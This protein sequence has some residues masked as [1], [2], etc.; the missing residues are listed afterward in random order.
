[1][2]VI[3]TGA[4][5]YIGGEI[6]LKLRDAGHVVVGIDRRPCPA[7]LKSCF[8]DFI[9]QDFANEEVLKFI[10]RA[11][12][13]AIIHCAGT[14]LVGPSI[15]N[16]QE[17]YNNNVVK[18][19]KLLDTV[20]ENIPD[21]RIIFSSSAAVYGTPVMVPCN[22]VDPCE[23]ISPYGESKLAIEWVL[24]GYQRAYKLSY[25]AFRYF[26]ACG[27]DS[28]GRHGQESGA[29]HIIARALESIKN[30]TEFRLFGKDYETP[31][32]TCVRDY[33]HVEDIADAHILALD[34]TIPTGVYNIGTATGTSNSQIIKVA[35]QITEKSVNAIQHAKRDG[36]P[37]VLTADP[38]LF[39]SISKWQP[40]YNIKD[41]IT[42]AWIWY[43]KQ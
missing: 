18:T 9:E 21:T 39:Q 14:S 33:I 25:V 28:Q 5:G 26:N 15:G 20:V 36:D 32:G 42:H 37:A 1:M 23:P 22:E 4:S 7:H 30:N 34:K 43:N 12:I 38:A 16:P 3:V 10:G 35:E 2:I 31:D 40:K 41:M 29:T 27:A 6:S 8:F 11:D 17:Y 19:I 24:R 13:D